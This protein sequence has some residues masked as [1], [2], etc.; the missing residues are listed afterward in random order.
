V[1][2]EKRVEHVAVIARDVAEPFKYVIAFEQTDF[3]REFYAI[4]PKTQDL[5]QFRHACSAKC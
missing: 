2:S 1:L 5:K 3:H 4:R